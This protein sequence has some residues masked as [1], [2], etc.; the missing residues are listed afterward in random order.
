MKH[1]RGIPITFAG[2]IVAF[3][4]L[5]ENYIHVG[6]FAVLFFGLAVLMVSTIKIPSFKKVKLNYYTVIITLFLLYM[7]YLIARSGFK[8]VPEFFYVAIAIYVVFI[9]ARYIKGKTPRFKLKKSRTIKL[10]RKRKRK[11]Q[12]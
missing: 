12:R 11:A 2:G 10:P 3:L 8:S 1:F 6:L 5:L 7:F 9:I 4:V